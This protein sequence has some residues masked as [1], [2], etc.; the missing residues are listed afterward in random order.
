M[1]QYPLPMPPASTASARR[2]L[3]VA[4]AIVVLIGAA[5]AAV[6][7][8][9]PPERARSLAR[10]Q[11]SSA[12]TRE[13]RFTDASVGLWPP[14]RITLSRLEIAE[15][16]GFGQG[17]ALQTRAIHLDLDVLALLA[18]R[19]VV[20][21]LVLDH[22]ALHLVL[23]P[24]G[25]TNFD[26]VAKSSTDRDAASKPMDLELRELRIE[27]G[28]AL[29]D[30]AGSRRR[31]T[32]EVSSRMVLK[33][34]GAGARVST[35]GNTEIGGLAFGPLSASRRTELNQSLARLGWKI[36]HRGAF[37]GPK[38]RLALE[39]LALRL[40]DAELAFSGLV[41]QPGPRMLVDLRA[42]GSKVKLDQVLGFLAVADAKA[43]K[44]IQGSGRLDFDLAV[45]GRMGPGSTPRLAGTLS[46]ADAAFR[47]PGASA[48][49]KNL[50]FR[51]RL[52]PDTVSIADLTGIVGSTAGGQTLA[53]VRG[54]LRVTQFADPVVRFTV[55]GDLD[56]AAVSPLL[57]PGIRLGGRAAVAVSGRGRARDPASLALEGRA[58]LAHVSVESPGLPKR[59]EKIEGEIQFS[60]ARA[61]VKGFKLQAGQSSLELDGAV[62]RPL[63]LVAKPGKSAPAVVEFSLRSPHLD[64]AELL[65]VTS[66]RPVL[67]NASGK[68]T[69]AIARLKNQ[70]LDVQN[71]NAR[72]EVTP[73]T[74]VVPEYSLRA[75]GG[76]VNGKAA[77]DLADP[78]NPGFTVEARVDTVEADALLS[79]WTPARGWIHGALNTTLQLSGDG[80][81]PE[82]LKRTLTAI[83]LALVS[84]GT[85]GPGPAL[86][87]VAKATGIPVFKE[88]RFRDLKLPF[89][90]ERGRMITDPVTIRGGYGE[91]QLI[92]GI[93]FDGT[94]DYTVSITLPS[95]AAARL[96]ARSALAAGALTDAKG[97]LLLDLRVT[98]P[99]RQPRVT[100]DS[101]AMRDRLAGK[102]SQAL[103]EQR[104]KMEEETRSALAAQQGA[105]QDSARVAL[106]RAQQAVKDS[107]ARKAGDLLKG[108]FGGGASDSAP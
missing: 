15:P 75:Y 21:R 20:K 77:F 29:I 55:Q 63:A 32:F 108:F 68:G 23:R 7:I 50:A 87:A 8:L 3:W 12:L 103:L 31:M 39:R 13:V 18:R 45:R 44:G 88:V 99:A 48:G 33:A 79:T 97:N 76:A 64:L 73:A 82:D 46:V 42:R 24:D 70:K 51:A 28:R 37:D 106:L 38:K 65:P 107:L 30:V 95:E 86:D 84:N 90:V 25:T 53:P 94:L 69:V 66:G 47:Y 80:T 71:V 10:Q 61:V 2:L 41:D 35:S 74:L 85:I 36:E 96:Q 56:L 104:A 92:G 57:A 1:W 4:A 54:T 105:I 26:G 14:V 22:P 34:E 72:I 49:V 93:G 27:R 19:I 5:W 9:L 52:A 62:M 89:R 40:G 59:V 58:R 81:T 102:V 67:P 16:G 11:L 17:A 60:P 100:W 83:G 78:A 43:L 98:G 101:Q 6:V 91:W